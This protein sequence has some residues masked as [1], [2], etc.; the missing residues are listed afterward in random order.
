MPE[1]AKSL[2]IADRGSQYTSKQYRKLQKSYGMRARM[3]DVGACWDNAVVERF[4]GS[5]KYDWLFRVYQPTS[6]A[7]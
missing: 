4:F 7:G 3:G 5:L 1:A 2:G 6:E